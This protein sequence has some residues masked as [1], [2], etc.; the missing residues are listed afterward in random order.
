MNVKSK[1]EIKTAL[2]QVDVEQY[3]ATPQRLQ[4][5]MGMIDALR[6]VIGLNSELL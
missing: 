2:H 3:G 6:W 5:L 1:D 4:R